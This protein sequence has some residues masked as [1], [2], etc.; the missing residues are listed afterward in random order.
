MGRVDGKVALIT[1]AARGQ[2]R[3]HAVRL[4]EEGATVVAVDICRQL[5]SVPYPMATSADLLETQQRVAATGREV[6][7]REVDVRCQSEIDDVVAAALDRFGRVDIVAANAGIVS[8]HPLWEMSEEVWDQTIDINLKGV[9]QTIKAVAPSMI[10]QRAGSVIVTSSTG[11]LKGLASLGHYCAAKH[12]LT[13]LVRVACLELAPH[14]VRVNSLNPGGVLT[15]MIDNE[16]SYRAFRPD[17]PEPTRDDFAA[18]SK[19]L[20]PMGIPWLEPQDVTNALLFL[21]S[22]ESRYVTGAVFAVDAGMSTA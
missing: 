2:G 5:P 7:V 13:G 20:H 4:A 12:G 1:G 6:M 16:M 10:S 17:L 21:A 8:Y 9:W 19:T 3:S 18:V 11:G 22:D 14:N 15:E